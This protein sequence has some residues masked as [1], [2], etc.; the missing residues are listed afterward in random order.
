MWEGMVG[1][2]MAL[3][4]SDAEVAA[5]TGNEQGTV[6]AVLCVMECGASVP[7]CPIAL[8]QQGRTEGQWRA[9]HVGCTQ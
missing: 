5:G 1:C 9:L 8:S 4:C 3:C 6:K 7:E 2:E